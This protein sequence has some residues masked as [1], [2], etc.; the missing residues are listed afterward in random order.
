MNIIQIL[1]KH[2]QLP[3]QTAVSN[4]V[5]LIVLL[6]IQD[7]DTLNSFLFTVLY[8]TVHCIVRF[9]IDASR[10]IITAENLRYAGLI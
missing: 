9:V 5:S 10:S 6:Y 8:C 3:I 4:N 1:Y 7:T 2:A